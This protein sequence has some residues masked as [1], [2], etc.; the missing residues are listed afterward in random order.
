MIFSSNTHTLNSNIIIKIMNTIFFRTYQLTLKIFK[1][2]FYNAQPFKSLRFLES[3]HI[4]ISDTYLYKTTRRKKSVFYN[5]AEK[6]RTVLGG[7][8]F[9][10]CI[11][12]CLSKMVSPRYIAFHMMTYN[13]TLTVPSF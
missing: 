4:T 7:C 12:L 6:E 5:Y 1:L 13:V 8:I 3:P 2:S 11:T 9:W 10:L